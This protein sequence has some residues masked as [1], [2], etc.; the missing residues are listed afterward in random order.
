MFAEPQ[1][2]ATISDGVDEPHVVARPQ[3]VGGQRTTPAATALRPYPPSTASPTT[4]A[5]RC[6][7]LE[8]R[9]D[10]AEDALLLRKAQPALAVTCTR[11]AVLTIQP[12][13]R[14]FLWRGAGSCVEGGATW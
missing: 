13:L 4:Q 7:V 6:M 1:I 9:T 2:E 14:P 11:S 10:L 8:T 5:G 3:L 12:T